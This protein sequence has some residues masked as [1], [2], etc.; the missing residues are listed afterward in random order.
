MV[1][2]RAERLLGDAVAAE[3]VA[4]DTFVRYLRFRR[5]DQ[6]ARDLAAL[7][8]RIATNLSLDRLRRRSRKRALLERYTPP[9]PCNPSPLDDRIALRQALAVTGRR[10]AEIAAYYYV[11]G[12]QQDEIARLLGMQRRTVGRR[13]ERFRRR[14]SRFL[15]GEPR[16]QS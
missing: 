6:S 3:D 16:G 8:Y 4:Q 14:A 1:R 11:D 13:L 2:K 5:R 7:L 10:E 12:M 9:P 15:H